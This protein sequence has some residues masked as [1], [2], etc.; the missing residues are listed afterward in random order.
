MIR[1]RAFTK[2]FDRLRAVDALTLEIPRASVVALLGPNGSGKTTTIKAAAGLIRPTAG[3][4]LLGDTGQPASDPD[5]R[6]ICSFL[7]QRVSFPEALTGREVV[8]FYR[9]L[10]GAPAAATDRVLKFASL[11]GASARPVGAY[12]G[13]MLQRLGLA[14]AMLPEADIL[15]LDEPTAA[16]DPDGLCALYGLIEERRK[17]GATVFFSSH[18]LGDVERLADHIAVLAKGRL[19]ALMSERELAERLA[20]RG[21]MRVRLRMRVANLLEQVQ[22]VSPQALWFGDELIVP[23]PAAARPAVL[24]LIR[25]AGGEI[26][27]LTAQEGRLDDF[28]RALVEVHP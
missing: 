23:G 17:A 15:L 12:S 27:G 18:Q 22:R 28:Y 25:T 2:D 3:D 8:E 11:N 9:R 16:L 10:R 7:P 26:T 19:V 5:A 4:V 14:V 13:G 24:D 6:R 21:V 20:D 1:Y